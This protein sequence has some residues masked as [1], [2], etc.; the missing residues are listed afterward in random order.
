MMNLESQHRLRY[1]I[2]ISQ[3]KDSKNLFNLFLILY[4]KVQY[5]NNNL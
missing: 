2:K 1:A 4:V 3:I 5:M